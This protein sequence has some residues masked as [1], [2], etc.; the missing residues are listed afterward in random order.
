MPRINLLSRYLAVVLLLTSSQSAFSNDVGQ[1]V[2]ATMAGHYSQV[3]ALLNN[4]IEPN[5]RDLKQ[6]TALCQAAALGHRRIAQLLIDFGANPDLEGSKKRRPL[7][8]ASSLGYYYITKALLEEGAAPAV[9]DARG[10]TALHYAAING[11]TRMIRLLSEFGGVINDINRKMR[12]PI[13]EAIAAG[14]SD[15]VDSLLRAGAALDRLDINNQTAADIAKS[16][17]HP[18]ISKLIQR[19]LEQNTSETKSQ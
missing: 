4:G 16:L 5:A 2:S 1:L 10:S 7:I 6:R 18:K 14:Q 12:T 17:G 11:D 8:M 9:R 19:H 15:A 3:R 13:M